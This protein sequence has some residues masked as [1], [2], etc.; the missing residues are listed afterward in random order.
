MARSLR[1][2]RLRLCRYREGDYLSSPN[3]SP[4]CKLE[5]LLDGGAHTNTTDMNRA[6]SLHVATY[7]G[8]ADVVQVMSKPVLFICLTNR[9]TG[10]Y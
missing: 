2:G 4:M 10:S 5:A 6:T 9:F 7:K 1:C 3:S 8:Y